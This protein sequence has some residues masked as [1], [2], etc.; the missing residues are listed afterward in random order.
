MTAVKKL[1]APTREVH[2]ESGTVERSLGT[3][4]RV[5]LAWGSDDA[6]VA[7]SCLV[8]P[9]VGDRVLCAT[10]ADGTFV[11]AVLCGAPGAPEAPTRIGGEGD[12]EIAPRGR[13]SVRAKTAA[14]AIDDLGFFGRVVRA[15]AA[16]ITVAAKELDSVVGRLAQRAK[17]VFRF[18][19]GM[20]Q[21][22]A[23]AVDVRAE[24]LASIRG[25]TAVVSAR[26]LAKV[27]G[28]QIHLG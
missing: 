4:L 15:E 18:V 1:P 20:D 8:E 9:D 28:Q 26:V 7:K 16:R 6:R 25:D 2:L 17:S 22:R 19:E 11:L 13:L 14:V 24:T 21:T 3:A 27:D 10:G 12:L 5:R 23:G